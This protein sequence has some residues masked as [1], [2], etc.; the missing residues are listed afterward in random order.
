MLSLW[1]YHLIHWT[2]DSAHFKLTDPHG[3]HELPF[4]VFTKTTWS[5]NVTQ[6]E[7]ECPDQIIFASMDWKNCM[8]LHLVNFME[9]FIG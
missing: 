9:M 6:I 7:K 5:K 8:H 2:D 3:S 4:T 1:A